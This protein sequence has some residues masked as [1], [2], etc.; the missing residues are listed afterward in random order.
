MNHPALL[1]EFRKKFKAS[2]DEPKGIGIE[3]ELPVVTLTGAVPE[4]SIIQGLFKY[5]ETKGFQIH[6]DRFSDCLVEATQ[7]NLQSSKNFAYCLDTITTEA[8][9]GVLEVVLA[10]QQNIHELQYRFTEIIQLLYGY[11]LPQNCLILGFGIQPVTP[12]SKKLLMPK[13]RYLFFEKFSQNKLIPKSKGSDAHLLT[14]TASNQ[15]HID[16]CRQQAIAAINVLNALS[17]LQIIL[18]ANSSIWQGQVDIHCKANREFF[19]EQCYPDRGKQMGIPPQFAT[20]EEYLQYLLEFKPMLLKREQQLLQILNKPTF[21]DF[22]QNKTPTIAQNLEGKQVTVQPQPTDIHYLN[23]FCYFNARLVP[24]YGTIESRM[25]CQQPPGETFAPTALALGLIEN[26][27]DAQRLTHKL[28]WKTWKNVREQ[29]G[30]KTFETQINNQSILPM[31]KELVDIAA[32]GLQK[33]HL[34]EECFLEPLYERIAL[35]KSPA[36]IA[37]DIFEQQGLE[38]FLAHYAFKVP[39]TVSVSTLSEL[40][41][42]D[43]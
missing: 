14:I 30:R 11:F 25:C 43:L 26:L 36:D 21:H 15:C 42:V 5:L 10:P 39:S 13:E 32:K 24:Q 12:P 23:T 2:I 29:A 34:G 7:I 31:L 3:A 33:R 17:G 20:I 37:N 19:W 35:Q 28:P 1:Y 4:F 6:R 40:Q 16:I 9:Y 8:G 41:P 22:L 27:T 18:H 38:A